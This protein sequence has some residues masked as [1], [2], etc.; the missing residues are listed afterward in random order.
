[1]LI[2]TKILKIEIIFIKKDNTPIH[3]ELSLILLPKKARIIFIIN[4]LE[5]KR[6]LQELNSNLE[7][8]IK[9]ELEKSQ[10]KR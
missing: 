6:E 3:L 2:Y 7:K 1:M 8:R 10:S 4:S 5:D 9:K